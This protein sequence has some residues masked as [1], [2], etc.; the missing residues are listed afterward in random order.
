MFQPGKLERIPSGS[1]EVSELVFNLAGEYEHH[2]MECMKTMR[3]VFSQQAAQFQ[4]EIETGARPPPGDKE[5][6]C[7]HE[8][9]IPGAIRVESL[10]IMNVLFGIFCQCAIDTAATDTDNVIQAQLVDKNRFIEQLESLFA[11]WDESHDGIC[12]L[13]EFSAHLQDETTQ[14]LLRSLDIEAR[15][16]LTLFEMTSKRAMPSRF[17]KC[18]MK[19]RRVGWTCTS[20]LQAALL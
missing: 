15:D 17:S 10:C 8:P 2:L 13:Q 12:S 3:S 9:A 4:A 7:P 6:D 16:A 11:S 18:W 19:I 14:A 5:F 20:S 1:P